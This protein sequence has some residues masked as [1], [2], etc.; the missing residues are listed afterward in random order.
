M[1]KILKDINFNLKFKKN[2]NK[3]LESKPNFNYNNN[4][5]KKLKNKKKEEKR[6]KIIKFK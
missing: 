1:K 4:I 6:K 2:N 3:I 5:K